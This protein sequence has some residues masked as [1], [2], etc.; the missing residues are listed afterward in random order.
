MLFKNIGRKILSTLLAG[1]LLATSTAFSAAA[2][3]TQ[4]PIE[5]NATFADTF[6]NAVELDSTVWTRWWLLNGGIFTEETISRDLKSMADAGLQ[7]V[8][9]NNQN[10]FWTDVSGGT[11]YMDV[12]YWILK[13]AEEYGL[14]IESEVEERTCVTITLPKRLP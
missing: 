13:Y 12:F 9:V 3:S 10:F 8:E 4:T 6:Q 11:N 5:A 14:T 2:A 7:N 1:S